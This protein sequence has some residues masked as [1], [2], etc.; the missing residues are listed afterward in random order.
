[1]C[2]VAVGV[3]TAA[4]RFTRGKAPREKRDGDRVIRLSDSRNVVRPRRDTGEVSQ[5]ASRTLSVRN[6][7][8]NRAEGSATMVLL[9][10]RDLWF[11]DVLEWAPA[12]PFEAHRTSCLTNLERSNLSPDCRAR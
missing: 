3:K 8:R 5:H 10:Y 1:M 7:H 9:G 2:S 6:D 4:R 11:P 12:S